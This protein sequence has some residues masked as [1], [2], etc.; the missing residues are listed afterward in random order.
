VA[1]LC[2]VPFFALVLIHLHFTGY[3][4]FHGRIASRIPFTTIRLTHIK[5]CEPLVYL[6][7]LDI[8]PYHGLLNKAMALCAPICCTTTTRSP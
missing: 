2:S 7:A 1:V 6:S 3:C 5:Y 4:S 8:P